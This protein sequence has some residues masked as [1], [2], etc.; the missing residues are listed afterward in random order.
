[1][2]EPRWLDEDEQR[3]WRAFLGATQLLLAEIERGLEA[4]SGLSHADY[5]MLVR[6]SEAPDRTLRMS[7]LAERSLFSRSRLS[8]AVARLERAGLILRQGCP[9]D[10]RGRFAKLT[11]AGMAALSKA[12]PLHVA[13]VRRALIDPLGPGD[14]AEL[15]RI[16]AILQ[17]ALENSANRADPLR[18]DQVKEC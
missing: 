6:L 9:S 7:S 11:E 15:G 16:S 14:F 3:C 8:H 5:E 17:T 1:M 2:T 12:A 18:S 10:R 4:S 13:T